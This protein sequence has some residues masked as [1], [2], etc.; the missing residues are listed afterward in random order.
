MLLIGRL[1]FAAWVCVAVAV[2]AG[3]GHGRTKHSAPPPWA[4]RANAFCKGADRKIANAEKIAGSVTFTAATVS[5]MMAELNGLARR[6]ML[7]RLPRSFAASE[8]AIQMLVT[9][10]DLRSIRAADRLLLSA[11]RNAA[12]AG[13]HCSF[14]A[15][16]LSELR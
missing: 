5:A 12:A 16:S 10:G 6:G 2:T 11:R 1:A 14:G 4:Q 9:S 8:Q 15:V 7:E 13:V 3:C